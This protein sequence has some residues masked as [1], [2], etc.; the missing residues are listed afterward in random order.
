MDVVSLISRWLGGETLESWFQRLR[1]EVLIVFLSRLANAGVGVGFV[2]ITGRHLGPAGRGE[3]ALAFTIAWAATHIANVGTSTSGRIRLLRPADPVRPRDVISLTIAL[4]PLQALLV[5]ASIGVIS[6]TSFYM[7]WEYSLAIVALSLATMLLNSTVAVLYGLRRYSKVLTAEVIIGVSQAVV[8]VGLLRSGQLNSTSAVL[9]MALGMVL[10]ASWLIGPV[11]QVRQK[12]GL[13]LTTHWRS[14][15]AEG[16]YPMLGQV[17]IFVA[18]RSDRIILAVV[19][20]ADSLG[21]YVV[22]LAIPE[23]LRIVPKAFGQV[24]ADRGR[25]GVD[26]IKAVRRYA[27]LFVVAQ[28]LILGVSAVV[29]STLL[30][31]VFGEGFRE[32]LGVLA[33]V[34]IAEMVLSI[35]FMYQSLL[36]GFSRPRGI[37][38]PQVLGGVVAVLLNLVM[39]PVWGM[40]GA[41][42]ACLL[43]HA[44][45]AIISGIW[46]NR[47]LRRLD[48]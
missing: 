12:A 48:T 41:A 7:T 25:S 44:A 11:V 28:V 32:A 16:F 27:R 6:L 9:T 3:I 4:L 42:Y 15:I 38:P 1:G 14:L 8:V 47:E 26:S 34:T 35:Y 43:G 29:G 5:V 13:G 24:I 39:I 10:G 30:L 46:T 19:A 21:L 40:R 37:G 18:L 2:V 22:A 17:S 45:L 23:T 31:T 36:V 20:G 33:I